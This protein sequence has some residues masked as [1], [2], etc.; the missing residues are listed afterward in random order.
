MHSHFQ[1]TGKTASVSLQT[2]CQEKNNKIASNLSC[3]IEDQLRLMKSDVTTFCLPCLRVLS[4][5]QCRNTV[6]TGRPCESCSVLGSIQ[7]TL[8]ILSRATSA[9]MLCRSAS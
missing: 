3:L 8:G 5:H 7:G 2:E 4:M 6:D 1:G 9:W